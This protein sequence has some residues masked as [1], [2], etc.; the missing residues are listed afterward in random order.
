MCRNDY[1][2]TIKLTISRNLKEGF[3]YRANDFEVGISK[4]DKEANKS[5]YVAIFDMNDL[6]KSINT[7]NIFMCEDTNKK[8][9]M[10]EFLKV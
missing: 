4:I 9:K 7:S 8:H 6:I 1:I 5:A 3:S 10:R 2:R